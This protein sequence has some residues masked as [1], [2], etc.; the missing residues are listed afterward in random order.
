MYVCIYIDSKS[1]ALY[2]TCLGREDEAD[3][4]VGYCG[5]IKYRTFLKR[6]FKR[7][8]QRDGAFNFKN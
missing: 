4:Y 2:R 6:T 7:R 5:E 1:F 8:G 3:G